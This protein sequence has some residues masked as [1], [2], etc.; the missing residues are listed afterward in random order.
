MDI[1]IDC[2]FNDFQGELISMA[3]CPATGR[4]EFYQCLYCDNPSEWVS[5][6][7]IPIL[8]KE[9]VSKDYFQYQL[10]TFLSNYEQVHVIAD[11]PEDIKHFCE[12]LITGPGARL[13]TP[14]LTMEIVRVEYESKKPHNALYD[15]RG[16]KSHVLSK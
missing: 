14:P 1:F 10:M 9:P 13:Y 3:L 8:D 16:L 11:W 7:V 6:N 15:A 5:K 2:E 12:S 4:E